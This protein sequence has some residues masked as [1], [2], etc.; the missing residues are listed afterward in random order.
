MAA[1]LAGRDAVGAATSLRQTMWGARVLD[2]WIQ[3]VLIFAGVLGVLGLLSEAKKP[4]HAKSLTQP[5]AGAGVGMPLRPAHGQA[6]AK[7]VRL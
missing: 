3:M 4:G 2:V 7:E 5:A 6:A 1:T